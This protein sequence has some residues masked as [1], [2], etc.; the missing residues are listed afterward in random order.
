MKLFAFLA[1]AAAPIAVAAPAAAAAVMSHAVRD[2][3]SPPDIHDTGFQKA[4]LDAHW[5]WRH[6]HCAQELHWN[7]E[8]AQKAKKS[9]EACT[10]HMQHDQA[11][12]NLSGVSPPP[13]KYEIWTNMARDCAH[14]WHE[15]ETK[16]PYGSPDVTGDSPYLHFTQMVWREASQ[17]GCAMANCG[18]KS[19]AARIYCFYDSGNNVADNQFQHNV[20]PPV[21]HDPTK[22]EMQAHFGY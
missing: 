6:I 5:Y 18:G 13:D 19:S 16:Y 4:I 17:I 8:L 3:T 11:G 7:D 9:V 12:S 1:L 20:W 14:G 21:C 2:G 15:E 10:E 22:G